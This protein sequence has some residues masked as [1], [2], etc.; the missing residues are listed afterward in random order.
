MMKLATAGRLLAIL[1]LP[2][3]GFGWPASA[4]VSSDQPLVLGTGPI[5]GH[6]F[7][8]GGALAR[9]ASTSGVQV[10]VEAT[11][12]TLENVHRLRTGDLD[13]ALLRSDQAALAIGGLH[14]FSQD[15][16]FV[17]LR[18]VAVLYA[19]TV[20]W[21]VRAD[22]G[23]RTVG[24]LAGV[25]V[26]LG[27]AGHPVRL[28]LESIL[29]VVGASSETEAAPAARA[30]D[31]SYDRQVAA[32]CDGEVDAIAILSAHPSASVVQALD[33]CETRLLPVTPPERQA[34]LEA[35]ALLTA[36]EIPMGFYGRQDPPV[37]AV[38]PYMVLVAASDLPAATVSVI[39]N[40]LSSQ[41]VALGS[42]HPTLR[43]LVPARL[44]RDHWIG[45]IHE[46][47]QR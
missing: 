10:V 6:A 19:E 35:I 40:A 2:L 29:D 38:G 20:T 3:C 37:P 28:L 26:N 46:G 45:L 25:R 22:S 1:L 18:I 16:P 21:V 42:L 17:R 27:P 33:A 7:A 12:G 36:E 30:H 47:A 31:L 24:D 8:V 32:L 5:R 44:L 4:Q 39:G 23:A 9:A 13:L 34:L 43:R 11:A 41:R 15:G 14:R